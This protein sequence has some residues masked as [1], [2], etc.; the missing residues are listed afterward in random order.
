MPQNADIARRGAEV[1]V[2]NYA[3]QPI[4]LVRGEG[5]WLYDAEDRRRTS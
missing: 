5:C 2:G 1:L 4:T 3:P